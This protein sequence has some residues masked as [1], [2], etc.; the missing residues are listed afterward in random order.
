MGL[1]RNITEQIINDYIPLPSDVIPTRGNYAKMLN[2]AL[3]KQSRHP[4]S[5]INLKSVHRSYAT[6]KVCQGS[7]TLLQMEFNEYIMNSMVIHK[8]TTERVVE[9]NTRRVLHCSKLYVK[10]VMVKMKIY[11]LK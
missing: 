4:G 8:G 5:V 1:N 2:V 3:K 9:Y 7:I 6:I 10:Q 11:K